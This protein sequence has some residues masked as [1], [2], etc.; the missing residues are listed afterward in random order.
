MARKRKGHRLYPIALSPAQASEALQI[1]PEEV[2]AAI[3]TGKL[4]A[5]PIGARRRVLVVDLVEWVRTW[6]KRS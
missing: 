3:K 6:S 5:Y 1:Q 4:V 2:T